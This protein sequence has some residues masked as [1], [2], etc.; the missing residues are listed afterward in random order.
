MKD[1][2]PSG[3]GRCPSGRTAERAAT[4]ERTEAPAC[5]G[6]RGLLFGLGLAGAGGALGFDS[7]QA[8]AATAQEQRRATPDLDGTQDR[9]SFYGR[10]QAGIVTPQPA[11][12]LVASFDVLA[13]THDDL[14]RL[15]K[16]LTARTAGLMAGEMPLSRDPKLPPPDNG[17]LGPTGF[18][19]DL[20]MTVAIGASLFDDRFG[21]AA[22]RPRRLV[23]MTRFPND[24]LDADQC[25]GDL[26]IQFNA[27]TAETNIHAL[28][29]VLKA[30]P[31]LLALRWKQEGF[32]PPHTV[33]A[34]GRDTAR[35]LLGFKD[36]TANLDAV[37]GPLMDRIVWVG[38]G[39]DEPAWARGGS[40]HVV[41]LIRMMVE[42][43]DRTPL[44]EQQTI[45]G[46]DKA[47]GAPLGRVREHDI[48]DY[49][50][51]PTGRGVP[52]D[53]HIRRA[54]PRTAETADSLILRRAYNYSNGLTKA[55]QLDM[56]LLFSSFQA[57]LDRGFLAVQK[58][59][60]GEPLEEYIKPFGGGYFFAVPGV[61]DARDWFAR[62]LLE[63]S[64]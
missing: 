11:A 61:A 26:L 51:D 56:G 63:D 36:G 15:M 37:D 13:S 59:L 41:R 29:E 16:N 57:D 8:R 62:G 39:S 46:R 33:K 48:P 45:I 55:G 64:A 32:L 2:K 7:G 19:D 18:P 31:A 58:R 14:V 49:A 3:L 35:N 38:E 4:A 60:D 44:Q 12:A 21:L 52:L 27:N 24:A 54:N 1:A 43:W 30:F 25:H 5:P 34:A 22:K 20:S 10:H 53:A 47:E 23:A 17:L 50:T 40:Y 42:R 6:R 28:R 9:R